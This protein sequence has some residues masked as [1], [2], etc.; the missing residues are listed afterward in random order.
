MKRLTTAAVCIAG[1]VASTALAQ[2]TQQPGAQPQPGLGQQRD[3]T[4]SATGRAGMHGKQIRASKVM[5]AQVKTTAGEELG[6]IEDVVLDPQSG[7]VEF[8]V[9]EWENKLVPVPFRA[10]QTTATPGQEALTFTAQIQ[11]D[12]L[13]TAPTI[14][15]RNQWAELQQAN[16]TQ[17]IYTHFGMPREAVGAPGLDAERGAGRE[18]SG[19][20]SPRPGQ[21]P[22]QQPGQPGTTPSTPRSPN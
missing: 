18:G 3:T 5:G 11:K 21:Q 17:R 4:Y 2:Q 15:D 19:I 16:F 13:Q 22:G 7:R 1:L 8:V 14:S 20:R 9:I 10:L 6:K 12:K